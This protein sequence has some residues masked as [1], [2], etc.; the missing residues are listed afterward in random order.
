M[1]LLFAKLWSFFGNEGEFPTRL[2]NLPSPSFFS[3]L[4]LC[5]IIVY[6]YDNTCDGIVDEV[7]YSRS[8]ESKIQ[9]TIERVGCSYVK[10]SSN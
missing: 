6:I 7:N 10:L 2:C 1:G 9:L 5:A 3:S 8:S 4:F